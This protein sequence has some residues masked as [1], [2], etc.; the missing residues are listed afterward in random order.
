MFH[1][2]FSENLTSFIASR[3]QKAG[4]I[5]WVSQVW[6]CLFSQKEKQPIGHW[7]NIIFEKTIS[8]GVARNRNFIDVWFSWKRKTTTNPKDVRAYLEDK[9]VLS[10]NLGKN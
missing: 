8:N 10:L 6:D 3:F 2:D 1:T 5:V 9:K 7:E 4:R